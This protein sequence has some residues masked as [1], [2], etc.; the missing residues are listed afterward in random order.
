MPKA[1]ARKAFFSLVDH[2]G[3][4]RD[5]S[6][7]L[8]SQDLSITADNADTSGFGQD[9]KTALPGMKAG[10]VKFSGISGLGSNETD[11]V[12]YNL[13]GGGVNG[14]ACPAFVW[15]PAGT[16]TGAVKYSGSGWVMSFSETAALADAVKFSADFTVE[17]SVVRGT[18]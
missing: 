15:A 3:T 6:R 7:F 5:L 11:E 12:L 4:V 16:A 17:G 1:H 2:G 18:F 9:W 13:V 10:A 8:N 14:T